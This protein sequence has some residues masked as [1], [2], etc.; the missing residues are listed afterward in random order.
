MN[1][2][3]LMGT[4][5][6]AGLVSCVCFDPNAEPSE[7]WVVRVGENARGAGPTPEIALDGALRMLKESD[8]RL[9]QVTVTAR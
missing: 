8:L 1:S 9:K 5:Q 2:G 3:L 6:V 4:A 7:S